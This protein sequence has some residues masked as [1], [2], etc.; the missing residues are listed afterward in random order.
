MECAGRLY[1]ANVE[2]R[3]VEVVAEKLLVY[4]HPDCSYSDALKDELGLMETEYDEINLA[5]RPEEWARL[6][7]LTGGERI[8]PVSVEGG[9][10]TVGYHGVG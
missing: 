10:V 6:E 4:T 1:V 9:V 8:T 3:D 7:D 2:E 5:L